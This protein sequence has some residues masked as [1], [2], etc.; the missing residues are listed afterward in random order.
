MCHQRALNRTILSWPRKGTRTTEYQ[1][2]RDRTRKQQSRDFQREKPPGPN[3]RRGTSQRPFKV[4]NIYSPF[5]NTEPVNNKFDHIMIKL[6]L[7]KD[8]KQLTS[9]NPMTDSG[10]TEHLLGRSICIQP[11]FPVKKL[12][13]ARDIQVIDG[14]SG[15]VGPIMH[16][17]IISMDIGNHREQI[18]F[19]VA[20]LHKH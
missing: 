6:S 11:Q 7:H 14:K 13:Q 15:S 1:R 18:R 16:E 19:Q 20:N 3:G 10:A 9:T 5:T 2:N 4:T 17:A 12:P 8:K